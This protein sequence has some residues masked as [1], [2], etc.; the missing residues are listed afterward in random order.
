VTVSSPG[1]GL[2]ASGGDSLRGVALLLSRA[3]V[4][5]ALIVVAWR[6]GAW[7]F[8]PGIDVPSVPHDYLGRSIR[9]AEVLAIVAAFS[10]AL[11]GPP[12]SSRLR[13]ASGAFALFALSLAALAVASSLWALYPVLATIKGLHLMIWTAFALVV[14]RARVPPHHMATAFVLGLLIHAAIVLGQVAIQ[15][16]LGLTALGEMRN[17]PEAPWATVA[18]DPFAADPQHFVRAY[19][20]SPHPNVLG[21]HL[22]I[23]LILCWGLA[24]DRRPI[25]RAGAVAAWAVLFAVLLFTFSRAA[26]FAAVMGMIVAALWQRRVGLLPH[27]AAR[28]ASGLAAI[29]AVALLLFV[30]IFYQYVA[31]R[32]RTVYAPLDARRGLIDAA[33]QLIAAHPLG[34]V[35]AGNFSAAT[36]A[37]SSD[38][39]ALD[40]VHNVPLL[41]GAEL[42]L[43]GLAVAG[44]AAAILAVVGFRRWRARSVHPWHGLIAGS[45]TALALAGLF[46][47]YPWSVPQGGLL[48]AWLAGWWLAADAVN[49]PHDSAPV[50]NV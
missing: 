33:L 12:R 20:L 30:A 11:A 34:G 27:A 37:V 31:G 41:I 23:G 25:A 39:T 44:G 29:A 18:A 6:L 40:A 36:R 43:A 47:H 19:G 14:A 32:I 1:L 49:G 15:N 10:L 24:V 50:R 9:P 21:G 17:R 8:L 28:L 48:G 16:P 13:G 2:V 22:A 4:L 3:A 42:G 35:G 5:A 46:D 26:F 7:T 45:L 38:G